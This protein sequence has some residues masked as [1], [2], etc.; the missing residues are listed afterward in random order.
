MIINFNLLLII[1]YRMQI[2]L[3]FLSMIFMTIHSQQYN[4]QLILEK[5]N[6]DKYYYN[7]YE[8][9]EILCDRSITCKLIIKLSY[10]LG[11]VYIA[12]IIIRSIIVLCVVIMCLING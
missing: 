1:F 6:H 9:N 8:I 3:I 11:C 4:I 5:H 7:L 12:T 2:S 10:Y